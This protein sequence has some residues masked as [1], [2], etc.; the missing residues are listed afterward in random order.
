MEPLLN[1]PAAVQQAKASQKGLREYVSFNEP[2]KTQINTA[3]ENIRKPSKRPFR[4]A[5][6]K[7]FLTKPKDESLLFW[8][9]LQNRKT[10]AVITAVTNKE[11]IRLTSPLI[12]FSE[13]SI[14]KSGLPDF[15]ADK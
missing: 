9:N 12:A 3:A 7:P 4:Y 6:A 1:A 5:D 15:K 14:I 2:V 8:I 11:R 10:M 13:A